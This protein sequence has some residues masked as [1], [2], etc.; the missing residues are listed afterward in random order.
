MLMGG[1]FIIDLSRERS[2]LLASASV[3]LNGDLVAVGRLT[4]PP[5]DAGYFAPLDLE[6]LRITRGAPG[7]RI[8]GSDA[9]RHPSGFFEV[10]QAGSE[11]SV[12]EA[13]AVTIR[14]SL[15][16]GA[17][18][19]IEV[20]LLHQDG[21][22]TCSAE[23]EERREQPLS[24]WRLRLEDRDG[25]I[26]VD[27]SAALHADHFKSWN[28]AAANYWSGRP[29]SRVEAAF[30]VDRATR[31][32]CFGSYIE[33]VHRPDS[34]GVPVAPPDF[35]GA[36]LSLGKAPVGSATEFGVS[37]G[38]W[39]DV[40]HYSG[41]WPSVAITEHRDVRRLPSGF[42]TGGNYVWPRLWIQG[43]DLDRAV[44]A[45]ESRPLLFSE[46]N[47]L[48]ASLGY[49]GPEGWS[50][51]VRLD[52]L[53]IALGADGLTLSYA[54]GG[55]VAKTGTKVLLPWE[56]LILRYPMLAGRRDSIAA[57]GRPARP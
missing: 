25:E 24:D 17:N 11:L 5:D 13:L 34:D 32:A 40:G 10:A 4:H 45:L 50:E 15:Q 43:L 6:A 22:L 51:W 28:R 56:L 53:E 27:L 54:L 33:S 26:H 38:R 46:A 35:D 18:G 20:H 16:F 47:G 55:P 19:P 7:M 37:E 48:R 36:S 41:R 29:G 2:L 31:I 3:D 39:M 8:A 30:A 12:P 44:A 42:L 57:P 52:S 9:A 1:R 14:H 21:R 23:G 49:D